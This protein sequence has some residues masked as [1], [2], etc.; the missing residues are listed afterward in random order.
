MDLG[1]AGKRAIVT[2]GSRGIGKATLQNLIDEGVAIATC[3][4]EA[5]ALNTVLQVWRETD[6]TVYGESVDVTDE[7]GFADWFEQ[8]VEQLGGL[9]I[10]VSNVSTRIHTKDIK[11][12]QDTFEIDLLHHIRATNLALPHLRKGKDPAIVYIS[13]IASIMSLNMPSETEYGAM[14]AALISYGAQLAQRIGKRNIRVNVVSPG[15]IHHENGF[16]ENIRLKR[17][18]FYNQ[19]AA[20]SVFNRLGSAQEVANAVTFLVSP[21]ASNITGVNLRVDGGIMKTVNF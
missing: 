5:D 12:W 19:V 10:F 11:R 7:E 9:D 6:A 8:S 18:E 17:P 20:M 1:L 4:R 14:K 21:A 16:W 13:S 15:P 2:G 3:A